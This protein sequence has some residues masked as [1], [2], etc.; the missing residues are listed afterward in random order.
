MEVVTRYR[1]EYCG[2]LF[3]SEEECLRHEE[4]HRK[5]NKAN[6]M[7]NDGFT[8]KEIND[9]CEIWTKEIGHWVN[10]IWYGGIPE[11][12]L[13]VTKDNCFKVSYWQGCEKPA[14]QIQSITMKGKLFLHGKGSWSGYY[15]GELKLNNLNLKDPRPK[16][17]LFVDPR[18][19]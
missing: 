12:L 10:N 6:E 19:I 15:G 4:R 14:Y 11:Y 7:L 8:L 2:E 17:E 9:E 3:Y 1:C 16:D 5:I 18:H 13:N